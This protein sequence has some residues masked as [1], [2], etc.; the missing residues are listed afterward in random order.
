MLSQ[1][2]VE[3]EP[4]SPSKCGGVRLPTHKTPRT[5]TL[6]QTLQ[7]TR[8]LSLQKSAIRFLSIIFIMALL[9][10]NIPWAGCDGWGRAFL[11]WVGQWKIKL[12]KVHL[13]KIQSG[14]YTLE[15]YK[16]GK[17]HS[18]KIH[19]GNMHFG[20]IHLGQIQI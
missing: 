13:E 8:A 6:S 3:R 11:L 4:A 20:K 14:K 17:I 15:K 2:R 18:G 16:F 7:G 10:L 5:S 9:M 12:G 1:P 19:F